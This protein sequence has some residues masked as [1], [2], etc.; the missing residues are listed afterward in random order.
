M[1]KETANFNLIYYGDDTQDANKLVNTLEDNVKRITETLG[2]TP[3]G[4][5]N[6]HVYA[7]QKDFHNAIGRPNAESW[8]VGTVLAGEIHMV[9][10]SNPG[11]EH[12]YDGIM[13]VAVH[14]FA[15]I[16]ANELTQQEPSSRPFLEEGLATY[17]AGQESQLPADA[18][19]PSV[20]TIISQNG[21]DMVYDVGY[22]FMKFIAN[23][24]G[25]A[26]LIEIYKAPETFIQNKPKLEEMWLNYIK[27]NMP[28]EG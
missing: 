22:V 20:S 8:V 23:N 25:N 16:V 1:K 13:A 24:F 17:L 4:K 18:E 9:S 5:T 15:H 21:G 7:T 11:P 28:K 12:D 27:N 19:I 26:G 10:P 6:V 3:S 14:E 2:I